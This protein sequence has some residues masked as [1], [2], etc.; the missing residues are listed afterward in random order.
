MK[1]TFILILIFFLVI[2]CQS[3]PSAVKTESGL[4]C[5]P[6]LENFSYLPQGGERSGPQREMI[7]P[8]GA[9]EYVSSIPGFESSNEFFNESAKLD[10]I[11]LT[12][13]KSIIWIRGGN[14]SL[15]TYFI[16]YRINDDVWEAVNND[17]KWLDS[18]NHQTVLVD[19]ENS[20]WLAQAGY[21]FIDPIVNSAPILSKYDEQKQEFQTILSISDFLDNTQV[22][23]AKNAGIMNLKIDKSG[24]LW[25]FFVYN[26][27]RWFFRYSPASNKLERQISDKQFDDPFYGPFAISDENEL[28]ILDSA[29]NMLIKYNPSNGETSDIKIP[30]EVGGNSNIDSELQSAI[31]F[32]DSKNKLWIDDRGWL[33][34]SGENRDW[35]VV[36]RSPIFIKYEFGLWS[37]IHPVFSTESKDGRLWFYSNGR[38]TGWVDSNIGKWC[39]FTT[40]SS[41]V[42]KDTEGNLW[43]IADGKLYK[44]SLEK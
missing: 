41:N 7:L 42:V 1:K 8:S 28:F 34:L 3:S 32:I 44:N 30:S 11:Q 6:S 16:H 24:A 19:Q 26:Q 33:D 5:L 12:N 15:G 27:E 37:W 21:N 17:A 23:S 10:L 20:V 29:M 25:F 38:G 14:S 36:I 4:E 18:L 2:S 43:I 9:W 40:F 35:H 22:R 31:F 39:L 13:G